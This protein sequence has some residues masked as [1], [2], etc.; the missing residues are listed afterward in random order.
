MEQTKTPRSRQKIMLPETLALRK[1]REIL[2]LDRKQ[3]A[4]LV[5]KNAKQL[6]KIENGFVE[7]TP[8]LVSQFIKNYG[9]S[10]ANFELLVEGRVEQVKRNLTP[11]AKKVI[12]NNKLRRSYKKNIT[13]EVRTLQVL[14]K[15]KGVTQYQA[16]FL[17]KYHKTAIGHIENGRVEIPN[18]RI[19]HIVKSYGFTM[20]DFEYHMKSERFVTDIQDECMEIIRGLSEEKLKAV[21]PLLTTFKA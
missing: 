2:N 4:I 20:K 9:F 11:K 19:Q 14:R 7:L 5:E 10:V 17:C 16:S 13:K 8:A 21:Y 15:L 1:M 6:E 12:E 3:A 18:S